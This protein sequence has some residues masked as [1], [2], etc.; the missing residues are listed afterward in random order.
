MSALISFI[1]RSPE[2]G[3]FAIVAV[4]NFL[5]W[6]EAITPFLRDVSLLVAIA[7][8]ILTIIGYFQRGA[9]NR[10]VRRLHEIDLEE[11]EL[12]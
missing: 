8:G 3:G 7:V 10:R 9:S 4:G 2:T 11:D 12:P 5:G 6:C 1:Q